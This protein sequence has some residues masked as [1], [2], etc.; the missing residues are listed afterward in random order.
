MGGLPSPSVVSEPGCAASE[1]TAGS[2]QG[3]RSGK[4]KHYYTHSEMIISPVL[5]KPSAGAIR[6]CV[7][8]PPFGIGYPS[9]ALL[10][11]NSQKAVNKCIKGVGLSDD[12]LGVDDKQLS[13]TRTKEERR[14]HQYDGVWWCL[15]IT[16]KLNS[17]TCCDNFQHP[18]LRPFQKCCIPRKCN[19][20]T[21]SINC[22]FDCNY[23][24]INLAIYIVLCCI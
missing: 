10:N 22:S 12:G 20:T 23:I 13:R 15:F 2:L 8:G 14:S 11:H 5:I 19:S 3:A 24:V 18:K 1:Q 9:S 21:I 7:C 17:Q 4:N 16:L 6:L